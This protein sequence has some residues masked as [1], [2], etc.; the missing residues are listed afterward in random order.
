MIKYTLFS[1]AMPRSR[2]KFLV[3]VLNSGDIKNTGHK[4]RFASAHEIVTLFNCNCLKIS[5]PIRLCNY[6]H[7][8]LLTSNCYS[9]IQPK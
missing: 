6:K 8:I 7:Y 4:N 2:F 3:A 5:N 1:A 9:P